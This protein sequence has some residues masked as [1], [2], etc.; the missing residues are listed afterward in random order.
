[1]SED[2]SV[3]VWSTWRLH[4]DAVVDALVHEGVHAAR[5][6]DPVAV[7]GLL[8]AGAVDPNGTELLERRR[9]AGRVTIVWGGTLPPPRIATL[10]ASGAAAYLSA[11]DS[12]TEVAAVVRLVLAGGAPSWPDSP[13]PMSSLTPR[14]REVA[15]AYLVTAAD[16]TR[17][18]VSESVGISERTLKVHIANI[19][20]KTGHE[21]TATR[22]GLRQALTFRGWLD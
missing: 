14:E 7:T 4:A 8:V 16:R 22:E 6:E 21:G 13:S 10:R 15:E 12:P 18:Q 11:L 5:V 17:A 20:D 19:R 3:A 2:L 1:M 9:R